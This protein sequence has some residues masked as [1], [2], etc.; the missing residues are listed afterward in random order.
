MV[1]V[2]LVII[3]GYCSDS[4]HQKQC[5]YLKGDIMWRVLPDVDRLFILATP[6][7]ILCLIFRVFLQPK[8]GDV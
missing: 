5:G 8:S 2:Q 7:T 6:E 1:D 3:T 4:C